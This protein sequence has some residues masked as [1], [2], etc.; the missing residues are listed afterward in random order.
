MLIHALLPATILGELECLLSA[1]I[2]LDP[3]TTTL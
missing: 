3:V 1:A 2:Y